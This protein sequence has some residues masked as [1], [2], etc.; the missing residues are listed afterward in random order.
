MTKETRTF[1]WGM[2]LLLVCG[3]GL[4]LHIVDFINGTFEYG[5]NWLLFAGC[6]FGSIQGGVKIT[7]TTD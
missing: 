6:A 4:A 5:W 2:T 1:I 3:I 7:Q